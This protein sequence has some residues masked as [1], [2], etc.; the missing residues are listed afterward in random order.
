MNKEKII[1]DKTKKGNCCKC[2]ADTIIKSDWGLSFG[3]C[4]KCDFSGTVLHHAG[5]NQKKPTIKNSFSVFNKFKIIEYS[6]E[7]LENEF[8]GVESMD[9]T[10]ISAKL[11][12]LIRK[13]A[14]KKNI[15]LIMLIDKCVQDNCQ[16]LE[17]NDFHDF[18][19]NQISESSEVF[20]YF[21]SPDKDQCSLF[22]CSSTVPPMFSTDAFNLII[23][24]TGEDVWKEI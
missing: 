3:Y 12:D 17:D 10:D 13:I 4:D 15:N 1:Y 19:D 23:E 11:I 20:I 24:D 8:I 6:L 22:V 9:G 7:G 18:I 21:I 2:G 14:K 5:I 16:N